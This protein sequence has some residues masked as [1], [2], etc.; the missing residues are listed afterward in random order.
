M[1]VNLSFNEVAGLLRLAEK[2]GTVSGWVIIALEWMKGA[3]EEIERLRELEPVDDECDPKSPNAKEPSCEAAHGYNSK[4]DTRQE[5][6][7]KNHEEHIRLNKEEK[8]AMG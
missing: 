8:A 5:Q 2:G 7:R 3:S 4:E 1:K 6:L